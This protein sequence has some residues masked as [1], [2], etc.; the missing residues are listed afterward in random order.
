MITRFGIS[1]FKKI[2]YYNR[3][4]NLINENTLNYKNSQI[5]GGKRNLFINVKKYESVKKVEDLKQ[6]D[7]VY[8]SKNEKIFPKISTALNLQTVVGVASPMI[9]YLNH[10]SMSTVLMLGAFTVWS[11]AISAVGKGLMSCFVM[12][13][14]REKISDK[15]QVVQ[16][17]K[18]RNKVLDVPLHDIMKSTINDKSLP[19]MLLD[20]GTIFF[21]EKNGH[22]YKPEE[23][24]YILSGQEYEKYI[25]Q[26]EEAEYEKYFKISQDK[27]LNTANQ[28]LDHEIEQLDEQLQKLKSN[29]NQELDKEIADLDQQIKDLKQDKKDN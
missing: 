1:Q 15:I 16:Y 6:E 20:G 21:F 8:Q 28:L 23:F 9:G 14:Y 19:Y 4:F 25:T 2:N 7:L 22:L 3:S 26:K 17:D 12:K 11:V 24:E 18:N 29:T 10:L 27:D 13:M 5:I